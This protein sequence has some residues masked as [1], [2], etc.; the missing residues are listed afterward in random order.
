VIRRG[1]WLLAAG[2]LTTSA[3]AG[4]FD[5]SVGTTLTGGAPR[6]L[7]AGL[8]LDARASNFSRV[9]FPEQPR[10]A[11]RVKL[12]APL[13]F[14]PAAD[15][16]GALVV[17]HGSGK[18]SQ[19]DARGRLSWALRIGPDAAATAPLIGSDGQRWVISVSGEVAG[20]TAAGK[21]RF[22]EPLA[23]FGRLDGALA[24]PLAT[25]GVAV[26]SG[27]RLTVLDRDGGPLWLARLPDPARALLERRG[28]LV[29]VAGDGAVLGRG[30]EGQL[31]PI[32]DLGGRPDQAALLPDG[33][34]LVAVLGQ[35][36]LVLLDLDSGKRRVLLNEPALV[37]SSGL[38]IGSHGELRIL[39]QGSLL[40]GLSAEGQEL[41]RAPLAGGAPGLALNLPAPLIDAR[42]YSAV[43]VPDA[44]LSI[45]TPKGDVALAPGS[46]C[47]EPLRP[48]PIGQGTLVLSCRSGLV[49]ALSGTAR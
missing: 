16:S 24:I 39:A 34:T 31:S 3:L 45:L 9:A 37:L 28:E 48:T 19:L 17:A 10:P 23:G 12:A 1:P 30:G 43:A 25:S 35:R 42:G 22:R 8:A 40:L 47:P 2:L 13:A 14:P 26:A 46:A 7:A 18:L 33:R 29:I 6:A 5:P 36:E 20:V 4:A 27:N 38:A 44:G 15:E 49:F 21:L 32:A 41:F 11:F